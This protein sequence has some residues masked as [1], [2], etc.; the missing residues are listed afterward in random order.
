VEASE[1][2]RL[3]D[4]NLAHYYREELLRVHHGERIAVVIPEENTRRTLHFHGLTT[5]KGARLRV[6]RY[7]LKLLEEAE[8]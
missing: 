3:S 4:R 8:R 5:G 7:A 1:L 6:S 2:K